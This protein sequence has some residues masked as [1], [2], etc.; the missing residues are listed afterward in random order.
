MGR[1]CFGAFLKVLSLCSP[2]STT[3]KYL[4]GTMFLAV[5]ESYLYEHREEADHH[6][7]TLDLRSLLF[8]MRKEGF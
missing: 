8:G 2:R 6:Q 4:C 3:N 5:N 1:Y 7:L